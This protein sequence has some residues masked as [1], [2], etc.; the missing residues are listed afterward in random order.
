MNLRNINA[1]YRKDLVDAI[2]DARVLLALIVP[3]GI[4]ILYNFM[5]EDEEPL[6]EATVAYTEVGSSLPERL[7]EALSDTV[8]L[9][10]EPHDSENEIRQLLQDEDA[11]MGLIIPKGFDQAIEAG[12]QPPL[13]LLFRD[14]GNVPVNTLGSAVDLVV[15]QMAGT[16]PP[17]QMSQEMVS[18][19]EGSGPNL[20]DDLGMRLYFVMAAMMM[21]IGMIGVLAVPIILAE[22]AEKKTLEALTLIASYLDVVVAKA[23]VGI[24][25]LAL[26]VGL[27]LGMTQTWPEDP[28]VFFSGV[29]MLG[30][31]LVGFGLLLGGL[32]KSANQLNNWGG[33]ILMPIIAPAFVIG[34]WEPG[35]FQYVIE[36][37]PVAQGMKLAVNGISGEAI[38]ANIWIAYA[39]LAA[40]IVVF[41]A[42]L[43]F[44]LSRIRN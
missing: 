16:S 12:E 37:I 34:V 43:I 28:A 30:V 20:F 44:R 17:V 5:F 4:A 25:Y 18:P 26:G 24:T 39:I 42:A 31:A 32:F 35:A 19:P 23:L 8:D 6:P 40:W 38:F 11:S 10:L 1:I 7:S 14:S 2:K 27:L 13:Q 3:F 9:Q 33:L 22:E 41:Y 21:L 15:R 36:A 29:A